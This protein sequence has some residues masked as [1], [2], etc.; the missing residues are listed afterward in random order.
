MSLCFGIFPVLRPIP[1]YLTF[2]LSHTFTLVRFV[3]ASNND[4]VN[5]FSGVMFR[6]FIRHITLAVE[7]VGFAAVTIRDKCFQH[8]CHF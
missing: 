5:R 4:V 3:P 8:S 1:T 6:S 7:V 2:W